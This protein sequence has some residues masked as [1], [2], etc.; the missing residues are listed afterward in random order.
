MADE[1]V[2]WEI[3]ESI[4]A[5]FYTKDRYL[6]SFSVIGDVVQFRRHSQIDIVCEKIIGGHLERT[7][8]TFD[9]WAT[10]LM[11]LFWN[12]DKMVPYVV[13]SR[14]GALKFSIHEMMVIRAGQVYICEAG[15]ERA[16]GPNY[17]DDPKYSAAQEDFSWW[18]E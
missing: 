4:I 2:K 9:F 5:A 6:F 12:S 17:R 15:K 14:S 3:R 10:T 18:T 7:G 16:E 1:F 11:N 13:S 8:V